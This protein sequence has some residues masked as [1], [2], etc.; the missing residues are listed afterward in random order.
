M[1]RATRI[2]VF[3]LVIL[4]VWRVCIRQYRAM[5]ER[6]FQ[7]YLKVFSYEQASPKSSRGIGTRMRE[8]AKQH[9]A[10]FNDTHN[11]PND[12]DIVFSGG[13][14]KNCYSAGVCLAIEYIQKLHQRPNLVRYAGASA[15]SHMSCIAM[16]DQLEQGLAWAFAV[17][18]TLEKF[19][20]YVTPWRMWT[21]FYTK[22]VQENPFPNDNK[23][24]I[25]VTKVK[26]TS[27]HSSL[28]LPL[29]PIF[30]NEVVST[31]DSHDDLSMCL[32]TSGAIPFVLCPGVFRKYRGGFYVD[33]GV[34]NNSPKFTDNKRPQLVVSFKDLPA[35]LKKIVW[36]SKDEMI[37]LLRLGITDTFKFFSEYPNSK[38]QNFE[39]VHNRTETIF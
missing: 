7:H 14:F 12:L 5:C 16:H 10:D 8:L 24:H 9:A 15:G 23:L 25:S 2:G 20:Y 28:P 4:L 18:E 38:S 17:S 19:P 29:R 21:H 37:E 39:I 13:G 32:L 6:A 1:N 31:F 33:G 26:M 11:L 27:I 30:E 3:S 22:L 34:T 35:R 36:F